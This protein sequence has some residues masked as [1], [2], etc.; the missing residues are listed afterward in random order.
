MVIPYLSISHDG[1]GPG[2]LRI[3]YKAPAE[4]EAIKKH[5]VDQFTR[6]PVL[7]NNL[8]LS[9]NICSHSYCGALAFDATVKGVREDGKPD[10]VN[11]NFPTF[12]EATAVPS[13]PRSGRII[14]PGLVSSGS[15]RVRSALI[16]VGA[17]EVV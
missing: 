7:E 3:F 2:G 10:Y 8:G 12:A 15:S 14:M 5:Y 17:G 16:T 1:G 13:Y 11:Y 4:I 9:K 6:N